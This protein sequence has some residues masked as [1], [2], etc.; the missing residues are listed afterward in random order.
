MSIVSNDKAA[1]SGEHALKGRAIF[2]GDIRLPGMLH[3]YLLGSTQAR[4]QVA[5]IDLKEALKAPGVAGAVAGQGLLSTDIAYTGQPFA[6]VCAEAPAAAV[7]AASKIKYD[8]AA[9]EPVFDLE[10]AMADEATALVAGGNTVSTSVNET[11]DVEAALAQDGQLIVARFQTAPRALAGVET[12]ACVAAHEPGGLALYT[13]RGDAAD[14]HGQLV[15]ELG[16][17]ADSLNVICLGGSPAGPWEMAMH[18]A[19]LKLAAETG[20]AVR[21][22]PDSADAAA[23][24]LRAP[25]VVL[26]GRV[27]VNPDGLI[28][29]LDL[30]I[31]IDAGANEETIEQTLDLAGPFV[32]SPA[33]CRVRVRQVLTSNPPAYISPSSAAA[34]VRFALEGLLNESARQ[35]GM[36][37]LALRMA[38]IDAG[39]PL[40]KCLEAAKASAE[41]DGGKLVGAA[42]SADGVVLAKADTDVETGVVALQEIKAFLAA[43]QGSILAQI[44]EGVSTVLVSGLKMVQGQALNAA[45]KRLANSLDM[46]KTEIIFVDG[47]SSADCDI[48]TAVAPA[49]AASAAAVSNGFCMELPITSEGLLRA[50]GRIR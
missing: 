37:P 19:A 41:W 31:N 45:E 21:F 2:A 20:R 47:A 4:G 24:G 16:I 13:N 34:S 35:L 38:N 27:S 42:C 32:Y 11:G 46:P 17:P 22:A 30:D 3:G 15:A 50:M 1:L 28:N 18:Y 23:F 9:T 40:T 44:Q 10:Q 5:N 8:M 49:V 33:N 7:Y 39:S 6:A 25:G 29:A 48:S 26:L 14:M 43:G 12:A 36:D